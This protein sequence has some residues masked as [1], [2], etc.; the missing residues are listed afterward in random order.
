MIY[1]DYNEAKAVDLEGRLVQCQ[2]YKAIGFDHLLFKEEALIQLDAIKNKATTIRLA[3]AKI[4]LIKLILEKKTNIS[5]ED[6]ML[7]YN[8]IISPQVKILNKKRVKQLLE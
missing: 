3:R 4:L 1:G 5:N 2:Y 7:L 8:G 6:L